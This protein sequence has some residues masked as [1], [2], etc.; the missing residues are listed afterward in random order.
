MDI[1]HTKR[2][3]LRPYRLEDT[4]DVHQYASDKEVVKYML[5][6]PN[7]YE[8]T[9]E[10][11]QKVITTYSIQRPLK[12]FEYAIEMNQKVIG[13]V[14]AYVDCEH[15]KAEMGWILNQAY[16]RKGIMTEAALALKEYLI[17]KFDLTKIFATCDSRNIASEKIMLNLGMKKINIQKNSR[18]DKETG[19]DDTADTLIYEVSI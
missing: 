14:S 9:K 16:H 19:L 3:T 13:G 15:K 12:N 4:N 5:F 10:F 11:V 18:I 8:E 1:I 7:S 17:A 2:L 6:G